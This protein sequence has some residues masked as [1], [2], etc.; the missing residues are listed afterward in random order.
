MRSGQKCYADQLVRD[1]R[2][3]SLLVLPEWADDAH[4][5]ERPF[6]S[7]SSDGRARHPIAPQQEGDVRPVLEV[8]GNPPVLTWTE[9]RTAGVRIESYRVQRAV[10]AGEFATLATPAVTYG[11]APRYVVTSPVTHTDST[12]LPGTYRYRVQAVTGNGRILASNEVT[13]VLS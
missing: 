6:A 13:V 2:N 9:A 10:G 11:G 1:G 3:P 12:A 7:S 5:Q 8:A 4:P